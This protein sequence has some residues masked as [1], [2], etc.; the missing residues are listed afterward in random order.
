MLQ[1]MID[2][3]VSGL[4]AHVTNRGTLTMPQIASMF[5]KK[6]ETINRLQ[7]AQ[8]CH[9]AG[10]APRVSTIVDSVFDYM[11]PDIQER[12]PQIIENYKKNLLK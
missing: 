2:E 3:E 10:K 12:L 5:D 4:T 7:L 8:L 1:S 6:F 11:L 9:K